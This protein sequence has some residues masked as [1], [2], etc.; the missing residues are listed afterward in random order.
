MYPTSGCYTGKMLFANLSKII[1]NIKN[2]FLTLQPDNYLQF[3]K[4]GRRKGMDV[5]R[6]LDAIQYI[7]YALIYA[8]IYL[9]PCVKEKLH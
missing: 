2:W 9:C 8:L 7:F 5:I 3:S 1:K 6:A 4:V